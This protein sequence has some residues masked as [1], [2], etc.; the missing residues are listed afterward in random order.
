MSRASTIGNIVS[1]GFRSYTSNFKLF[2]AEAAIAHLWLIVPIYGLAKFFERSAYI[3]HR[4][5]GNLTDSE[6]FTT[7]ISRSKEL[8]RNAW[9]YL[10]SNILTVLITL[11]SIV[12]TVLALALILMLIA[13]AIA[14]LLAVLQAFRSHEFI[15]DWLGVILGILWLILVPVVTLWISCRLW[16]VDLFLINKSVNVVQAIQRSWSLTKKNFLSIVGVILLTVLITSPLVIALQLL[17][18]LTT[19]LI[20]LPFPNSDWVYDRSSLVLFWILTLIL[21][22]ITLPI[23]QSIKAVM[24]YDL[25]CY[26]QGY[27]LRLRNG[28]YSASF[29]DREW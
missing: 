19:R 8:N 21:S 28:V 13:V 15:S 26:R 10:A 22:I 29:S 16:F 23:W 17:G 5:I 9:K 27:D 6:Q 18:L 4:T 12:T 1:L 3:A 20:S 2:L 25:R 7:D 11:V 14:I 24:F